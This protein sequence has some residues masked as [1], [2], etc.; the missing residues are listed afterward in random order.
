MPS[1]IEYTCYYNTL[2]YNIIKKNISLICIRW[3]L[4]GYYKAHVSDI[5]AH[6]DLS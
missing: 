4:R 2:S 3:E 5:V 6:N 1:Q